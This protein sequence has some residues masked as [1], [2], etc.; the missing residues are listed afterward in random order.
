MRVFHSQ[1]H[2]FELGFAPFPGGVL[3]LSND[4]AKCVVGAVGVSGATADQDEHCGIIGAKGLLDAFVFS[5]N[6]CL[7]CN[8]CRIQPPVCSLNLQRAIS[9]LIHRK[10]SDRRPRATL[11]PSCQ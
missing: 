5:S 3:L 10:K 1:C 6:P 8:A 11:S 4:A 9:R 7:F 2:K